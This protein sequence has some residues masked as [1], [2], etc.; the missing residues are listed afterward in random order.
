MVYLVNFRPVN[1]WCIFSYTFPKKV[2]NTSERG[3]SKCYAGFSI[4][5]RKELQQTGGELRIR[6]PKERSNCKKRP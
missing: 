2:V 4:S 5:C 3:G 1:Y 6:I